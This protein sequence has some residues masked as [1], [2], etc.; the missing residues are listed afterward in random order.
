MSTVHRTA[1]LV[2]RP[3]TDQGTFGV[4]TLDDGTTFCTGERPDR[5]NSPGV[6]CIPAGKYLCESQHSARFKRDV[7][8]LR[9]VP[10]RENI[11]IHYGN[12]CGDTAVGYRSDVEGCIVLGTA[13]GDL[14]DTDKDRLQHGV[15]HSMQA[16]LG[17]MTALGGEPFLLTIERAA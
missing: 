6:S 17:L 5:D 16:F 3:S 1:K 4:L 10:G 15:M 8:V 13:E 7:Y 11:E 14:W 2:S 9:D 12:F